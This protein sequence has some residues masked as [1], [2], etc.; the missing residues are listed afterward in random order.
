MKKIRKMWDKIHD[1]EQMCFLERSIMSHAVKHPWP[2]Q[3]KCLL[4]DF[5]I[6]TYKKEWLII[7]A[8][9]WSRSA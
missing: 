1:K 8:F 6:L 9:R 4:F 3:R 2:M 5:Q 7:F